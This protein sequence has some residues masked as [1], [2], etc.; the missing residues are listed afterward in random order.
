M[1]YENCF[2]I[3]IEFDF[4]II[5]SMNLFIKFIKKTFIFFDSSEQFKNETFKLIISI[6]FK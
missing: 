3:I 6:F 1:K 2:Q 4:V 5:R